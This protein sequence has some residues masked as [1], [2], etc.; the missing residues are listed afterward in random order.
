MAT[1]TRGTLQAGMD[2]PGGSVID[3]P[4]NM[5]NGPKPITLAEAGID[6]HFEEYTGSDPLAYVVSLNLRRRH[7]DESQ[8]AM[9]AARIATLPKRTNQHAPIAAPSQEVAADMLNVGRRSVQ[10]AREVL[11]E[12][13]PELAAKVERGEISVSAAADCQ[14]TDRRAAR[15]SGAG[16]RKSPAGQTSGAMRPD[17]PRIGH[18]GELTNNEILYELLIFVLNQSLGFS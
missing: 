15:D 10:R 7:L 13:V 11:E 1:G 3:P 17:S 18:P 2:G 14:C 5:P 9:V 8:R 6:P 16:E 12:G 4:G